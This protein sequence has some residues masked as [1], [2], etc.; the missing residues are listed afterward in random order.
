MT[1]LIRKAQYGM[2]WNPPSSWGLDSDDDTDLQESENPLGTSTEGNFQYVN[3]AE[4]FNSL[5]NKSIDLSDIP[6]ST[7]YAADT[8]DKSQNTNINTNTNTNTSSGQT[9]NLPAGGSSI[10]GKKL[11]DGK[12]P[13]ANA[14]PYK[15]IK[16]YDIRKITTRPIIDYDQYEQLLNDHSGKL[17]TFD[18]VSN[19][20]KTS[21]NRK[22]AGGRN[23]N[24]CNV[25]PPSYAIGVVGR[26]TMGDGQRAAVFD[27]VENGIA[28]AMRLYRNKYGKKNI[29]QMNNGMQSYYKRNEPMGLS[30]LRLYSVTK[31]CKQLGISPSDR[32]NTD[33]KWTLCSFVAI[34]AKNETGS[35]LSRETLDRAYK[36]AFG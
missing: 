31:K 5:K 29:P 35:T 8:Q 24:P 1:K 20:A 18:L 30:A 11:A 6:P 15:G 3:I 22:T 25:S 12:Y 28:T 7:D 36:I 27:S 19:N 26:A 9:S 10:T 17:V 16:T 23:N 33:D 34:T 2:F 21:I 4:L 32:L 14:A 13:Y